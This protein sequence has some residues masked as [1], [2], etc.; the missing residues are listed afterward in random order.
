MHLSM[1]HLLSPEHAKPPNAV[2]S[3]RDETLRISANKAAALRIS[4]VT[5]TVY[6]KKKVPT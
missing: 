3:S 1:R 2:A 4:S 5:L 6:T